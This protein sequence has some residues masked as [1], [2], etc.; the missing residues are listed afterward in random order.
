MRGDPQLGFRRFILDDSGHHVAAGPPRARPLPYRG[1]EQQAIFPRLQRTMKAQERSGFKTIAARTNRLGRVRSIHTPATTRSVRWRF[2]ARFR[3]RLRISNCCLRSTDSAITDRA[4][5]RTGRRA[6]VVSR[7]GQGRRGRARDDPTNT[8][9]CG[10]PHDLAIRHGQG[11]ENRT[12][13]KSRGDARRDRT[14][15]EGPRNRGPLAASIDG[16]GG[17]I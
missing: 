15:Q 11:T 10:N 6:I 16:C 3:V 5:T 1:R 17:G 12:E 4:P 2:G 9:T 7:C 13:G 14:K 8:P